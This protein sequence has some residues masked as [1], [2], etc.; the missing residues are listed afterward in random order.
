MSEIES[1]ATCGHRSFLLDI[2]WAK[3]A[4]RHQLLALPRG[5][6]N[7]RLEKRREQHRN[8]TVSIQAEM[9]QKILYLI[10]MT[11]WYA[12]E[13]NTNFYEISLFGQEKAN[14]LANTNYTE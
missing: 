7:L 9:K 8:S 12:K 4:L 14:G 5:G 2:K 13:I 1:L 3:I 6:E 11:L 10:C